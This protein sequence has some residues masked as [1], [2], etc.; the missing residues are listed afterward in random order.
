MIEPPVQDS[1]EGHDYI[2][3]GPKTYLARTNGLE[4]RENLSISENGELHPISM[5]TNSH[6]Q[7]QTNITNKMGT[8][9]TGKFSTDNISS[10]DSKGLKSD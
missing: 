9:E 2:L 8:V 3:K 4:I 7:H 1:N 5:I 6:F 10:L